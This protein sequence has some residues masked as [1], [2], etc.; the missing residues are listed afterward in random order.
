MG[1]EMCI[2]DREYQM[3]LDTPANLNQES[4][5]GEAPVLGGDDAQQALGAQF[6]RRRASVLPP[7]LKDGVNPDSW[8]HPLDER[9]GSDQPAIAMPLRR[10]SA[11]PELDMN[12]WA[13]DEAAEKEEANRISE[14]EEA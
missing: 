7:M 14:G 1:S 6:M 13:K 10:A 11:S 4:Q 9:R 3:E 12:L 8:S 5:L 2:R